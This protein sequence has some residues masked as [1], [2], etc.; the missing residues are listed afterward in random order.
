MD[1]EA[2]FGLIFVFFVLL[3]IVGTN[4]LIWRSYE[5][6]MTEYMRM[7]RRMEQLKKNPYRRLK[8]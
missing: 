7:K 8:K 5:R 4:E 1:V 3:A 6:K 2:V